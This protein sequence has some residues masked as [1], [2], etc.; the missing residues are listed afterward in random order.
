MKHFTEEQQA[1]IQHEGN[2][3]L[4]SAC[5][6]SGKTSVLVEYARLRPTVQMVYLAYNRAIKEEAEQRFSKNVRCVTTHGLAYSR[7]GKYFQKKLNNPKPYQ[8]AKALDIS[9]TEA[10]SL[11]DA[12]TTFLCSA[13]KEILPKHF[14]V[15]KNA[16]DEK[17]AIELANKAWKIMQDPA[18]MDIPMPHDGYLKLFHLSGA[19]IATDCILFDEFQ[20]ANEVTQ[21]IVANQNCKKIYVG[22]SRQ[23]IYAFRGAKNT[24]EK[25]RID[26]RLSLTN[27]FRFGDGIAAFANAVLGEYQPHPEKIHGLGKHPTTFDVDRTRPHTVL[28][29]TNGMLFI[30]AVSAL[31]K[32]YP[33][34]FVGGVQHYKFDSILDAYWLKKERKANIKDKHI[35][36][37][38][39]FDEMMA[40]AESLDDCE[41][42]FLGRVVREY[43]DAIPDLVK[44]IQME[45]TPLLSGNEP[46]I[47]MTTGH[48]SKGLE[49]KDV[50]LTED[51]TD[52]KKKFDPA[53]DAEVEPDIQEIN[54]LYVASTRAQRS[55]LLP[56]NIRSWLEETNP[57]L[58]KMVR[59]R[60][61]PGNAGE[62]N[63]ASS[64]TPDEG[65]NEK[66]ASPL[67][68]N[69]RQIEQ[70]RQMTLGAIETLNKK[71]RDELSALARQFSD[72][73]FACERDNPKR[74]GQLGFASGLITCLLNGE[75]KLVS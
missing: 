16:K 62:K 12:V 2:D 32:G 41:L 74:A 66:Q 20:D 3:F 24:M 29:R 42:R 69:G 8:F 14:L 71:G 15:A 25:M 5:S 67:D 65:D 19:T 9:L 31:K 48:R 35:Q 26:Q 49:W 33:F 27:S 28:C 57:D 34:G 22:D 40:Y 38:N 70:C 43:G 36:S 18:D 45:A 1:V 59:V 52:M 39:D 73:A 13:D 11:V 61:T 6:G 4:V 54:L 44:R 7:F 56:A 60:N 75:L 23:S 55:L 63:L 30:E 21:A 10:G 51:F 17:R 50:V 68:L 47:V 46:V 37:F 53:E 72:E 58:A 64:K